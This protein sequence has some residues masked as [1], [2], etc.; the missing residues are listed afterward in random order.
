MKNNYLFIGL[1]ICIIL[2][3]SKEA[4]FIIEEVAEVPTVEE[5]VPSNR[6]CLITEPNP[7]DL[8]PHVNPFQIVQGKILS[9]AV[10]IDEE[11]TYT[12][13]GKWVNLYG[14]VYYRYIERAAGG[15]LNPSGTFVLYT[16][17]D[18]T[19]FVLYSLYWK[20]EK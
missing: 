14:T 4:P 3:C 10:I 2:G 13:P 18:V 17:C 8:E 9:W 15:N 7:T 20:K 1:L 11:I 12:P 6:I 5:E 19:A 16:L